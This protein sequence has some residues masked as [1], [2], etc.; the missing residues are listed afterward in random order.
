MTKNTQDFVVIKI[1]NAQEIVS[2]DDMITV[3][4]MNE[5]VGKTIEIEEVLLTHKDGKTEVG[6]PYVKGTKVTA[7]VVEH[8][9]GEKVHTRKFKAKSRYRKHTGARPKLTVLKIKDIK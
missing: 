5:E 2:K 6:K 8:T 4:L 7:E 9:K 1:K 3:D